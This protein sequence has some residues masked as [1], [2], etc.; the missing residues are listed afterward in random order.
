MLLPVFP[1]ISDWEE[2]NGT[3]VPAYPSRRWYPLLAFSA[4]LL[5][6][7]YTEGYIQY[8]SL[9]ALAL[10]ALSNGKR[11]TIRLKY[12]F[13]LYYPLHLAALELIAA[14]AADR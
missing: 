12:F 7:C 8:F 6:V 13:Y 11:G 3:D 10:L 14:L 5:L 9:A 2:R 4:G 1:G